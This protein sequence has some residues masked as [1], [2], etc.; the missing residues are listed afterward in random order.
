MRTFETMLLSGES[1][2]EDVATELARIAA[3]PTPAYPDGSSGYKCTTASYMKVAE[4]YFG[5]R[6]DDARRRPP[7]RGD[8][9][10]P[11]GIHPASG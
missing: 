11:E 6:P 5:P 2:A 3:V 8:A 4:L 7:D 9:R 1:S 10:V